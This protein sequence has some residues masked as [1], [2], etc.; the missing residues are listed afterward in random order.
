M[1]RTNEIVN[2]LHANRVG[3][4]KIKWNEIFEDENDLIE[5][6]KT[7]KIVEKAFNPTM[8][9]AYLSSFQKRVLSGNKLTEKQMVQLKRLASSVAY[10]ILC[11]KRSV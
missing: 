11:A 7:I 4:A 1:K 9:Y 8:G 10:E 5:A 6:L 3:L 2:K